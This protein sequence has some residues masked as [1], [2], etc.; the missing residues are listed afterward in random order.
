M[1]RYEVE[2]SLG[3]LGHHFA[4]CGNGGFF[5]GTHRRLGTARSGIPTQEKDPDPAGRGAR[6]TSP[7]SGFLPDVTAGWPVGT[8]PT[9]TGCMSIGDWDGPSS[10]R[11]NCRL[12]IAVIQGGQA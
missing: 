5:I 3:L 2:K 12:E 8:N 11:L 1:V 9:N 10:F 6:G 7:P 4:P